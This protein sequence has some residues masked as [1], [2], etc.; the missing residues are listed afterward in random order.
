MSRKAPMIFTLIML[1]ASAQSPSA[2]PTPFNFDLRE[3][4]GSEAARVFGTNCPSYDA[5]QLFL[6]TAS[7]TASAMQA[8][9]PVHLYRSD[10]RGQTI[11]EKFGIPIL[12]GSDAEMF[13]RPIVDGNHLIE[14]A[15]DAVLSWY[16]SR[17][18][19]AVNS[20]ER[21]NP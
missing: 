20:T 12:E 17:G 19:Y 11:S 15:K 3:M 5:Q 18:I 14:D 21:K 13:G 6:D 10:S 2:A 4:W 1:Q 9:R 16:A 8:E 7:K